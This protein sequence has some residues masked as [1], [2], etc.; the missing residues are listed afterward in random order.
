MVEAELFDKLCGIG[1]QMR[2]KVTVPF[3]G[4]QVREHGPPL[5]PQRLTQH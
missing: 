4:I 5:S 1:S 3:G 2:R